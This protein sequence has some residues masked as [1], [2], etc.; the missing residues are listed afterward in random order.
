MKRRKVITRNA[1]D[2]WENEGGPV[3]STGLDVASDAPRETWPEAS[4]R[5]SAR[6]RLAATRLNRGRRTN[7]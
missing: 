1:L 3:A 4:A 5:P 6:I 7:R 2:A